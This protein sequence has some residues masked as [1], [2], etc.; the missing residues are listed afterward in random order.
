MEIKCPYCYKKEDTFIKFIPEYKN[1]FIN[2]NNFKNVDNKI[3]LIFKSIYHNILTS[4]S[5]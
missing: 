2:N 4:Q 1:K 3:T 5:C